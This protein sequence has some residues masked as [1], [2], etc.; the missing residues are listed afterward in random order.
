MCLFWPGLVL[1]NGNMYVIYLYLYD[2]NPKG[3]F[4]NEKNNQTSDQ[5]AEIS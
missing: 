1:C 3:S 2:V 5:T 4:A